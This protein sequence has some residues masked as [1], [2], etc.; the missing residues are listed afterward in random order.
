[1]ESVKMGGATN[2][3]LWRRFQM[4]FGDRNNALLTCLLL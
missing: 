2:R 3:L 4:S 1:M